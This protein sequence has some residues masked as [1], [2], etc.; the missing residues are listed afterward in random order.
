MNVIIYLGICFVSIIG[1]YA[2]LRYQDEKND[3]RFVTMVTN[4]EEPEY[5]YLNTIT[6]ELRV[7]VMNEIVMTTI[8]SEYEFLG[9][10]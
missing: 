5:V 6:C 8:F 10:L 7:S 4:E 3:E 9:E 1:I 2:C